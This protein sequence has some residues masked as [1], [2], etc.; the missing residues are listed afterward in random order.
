MMQD[1]DIGGSAAHFSIDNNEAD[2]PVSNK[3]QD[4]KQNEPSE[5]A[6]LL[7]SIGETWIKKH[8]QQPLL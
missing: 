6:C 5:K 8:Y 4:D 1:V 2:C 3:A 7:Y